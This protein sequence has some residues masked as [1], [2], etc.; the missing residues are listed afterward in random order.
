VKTCHR[1]FHLISISGL[2][3]F[4]SA[5]FAAT[6]ISEAKADSSP[7]TITQPPNVRGAY[8]GLKLPGDIPELFAPGIINIPGRSVSRIAFS[9]DATECAFTVFE[10]FYAN[11]RILFTRY[12]NGAWTS[13][14][15]LSGVE[16]RQILEPLFSRDN[17]RL[18]FTVKAAGDSPNNDFWEMQRTTKGW[19]QP[20]LLPAPLNSAQNEFCLAQTAGGTMYFAS[21]RE[22]GHGGLDLYRTVTKPGQPMQ[23]EN[24]GTP[25]NSESDDGDPGISPDGHTL[26]FYSASNRPRPTGNSDLFICFEN[27]KGGWTNP[28]NLGKGFNTP[29][30]E[31]GATFSQ[32]GRVL[33]FV[34]FDGKKG[35]L[36]WVSTGALERFRQQSEASI[37]PAQVE[38][39]P[40]KR[41]ISVS[42]GILQRYVGTYAMEPQPGFTNHITLEG[43]QLMTQMAGQPKVPLFAESETKFFLKVVDAQMEFVTND[44]GETTGLIIHQ[45]GMEIKMTRKNAASNGEPKS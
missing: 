31:Y 8:F 38:L 35:E 23:V 39:P 11:N 22:G 3:A 28:V 30:A 27:G 43:N 25:V 5:A 24:L 6:P 44:Q 42:P 18:Y 2:V 40:E 17:H 7:A 4:S 36:Y 19:G 9:P 29:A 21:A 15:P 14:A 12:E 33:F 26:V 16:G 37:A 41:A 10:S 20:Q 32:D 45:N 1:I 13:Q 34:R